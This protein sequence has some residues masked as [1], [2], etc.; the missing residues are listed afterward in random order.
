MMYLLCFS[1]LVS[2]V[3]SDED[4]FSR[5]SLTKIAAEYQ[6]KLAQIPMHYNRIDNETCAESK[7]PL[8]QAT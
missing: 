4:V 7:M 3:Q 2:P 6:L 5:W 1:P 8:N